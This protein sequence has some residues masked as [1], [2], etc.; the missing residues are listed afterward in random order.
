MTA[1]A[2]SKAA[3]EFQDECSPP[4]GFQK[5]PVYIPNFGSSSEPLTAA[6]HLND[7]KIKFMWMSSL[8]LSLL[9]FYKAKGLKDG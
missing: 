8:S 3:P 6:D 2:S 7:V 4:S 1:T 9:D 5:V